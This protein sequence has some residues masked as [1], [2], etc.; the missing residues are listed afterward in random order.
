M[1]LGRILPAVL[2]T[3]IILTIASSAT[4]AAPRSM[5]LLENFTNYQ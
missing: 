4:V 1:A 2:C 3:A 5:V